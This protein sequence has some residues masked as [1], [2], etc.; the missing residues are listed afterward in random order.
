MRGGAVAIMGALK[1][2]GGRRWTVEK[3][4]GG[5]V[6]IW[7]DPPRRELEARLKI[8]NGTPT[9]IAVV[10]REMARDGQFPWSSP[11]D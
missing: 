3:S 6:V 7:L 5:G 8:R 2:G 1:S 9:H 10:L 4:E 11:H